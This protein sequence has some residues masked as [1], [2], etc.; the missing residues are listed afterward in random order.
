MLDWQL[1]QIC[2]PLEIKLLLLLLLL[3]LLFTRADQLLPHFLIKQ[4]ETLPSQYRHIEH[5]RER[6]WFPK[7]IIDKM[8]AM[9]TLDNFSGLYQNKVMLVL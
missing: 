4:F 5:M 7:V 3:L 8:A 9:R 6:V 2:Y 1:C